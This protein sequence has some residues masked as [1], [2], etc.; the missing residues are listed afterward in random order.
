VIF[1]LLA[2][3]TEAPEPPAHRVL[4]EEVRLE[5]PGQLEVRAAQ[6]VAFDEGTVVAES[7]QATAQ[8]APQLE[9]DAPRSEWDLEARV[10]R[11]LGGVTAVRGDVTLTCDT[12]TVRMRDA[13]E[14]ERATA[15]GE[16]RVVRGGRVATGDMAV[17]EVASGEVRLT[18]APTVTDGPNRMTG[19]KIT[20]FL[21][22]ERVICDACRLVVD[23]AAV[24]PDRG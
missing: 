23:G 14:V 24:L 4:L 13:E 19:E 6:A 7:V 22:D 20:L 2:C 8:G 10:I 16:V 12:L 18:G 1:L 11:F 17:L 3:A 15:D 21:D 9:I 5:L